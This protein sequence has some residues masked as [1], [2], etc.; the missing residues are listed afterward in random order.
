M[1]PRIHHVSFDCHDTHARSGLRPAVPGHARHAPGDPA[2]VLP[3]PG[4]TTPNVFFPQVTEAEAVRDR[5]HA[6][7]GPAGRNR[8]VARVPGLA[9]AERAGT[10]IEEVHP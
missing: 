4:G 1:Y 2:A 5:V 10:T 7:P 6:R 3:P 8:E 9:A